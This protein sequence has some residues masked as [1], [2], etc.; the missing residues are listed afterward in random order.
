[1]ARGLQGRAKD[2]TGK[3]LVSRGDVLEEPDGSIQVR[4]V[5]LD[6]AD[7]DGHVDSFG[8]GT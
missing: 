6:I 1:M 4:A 5:E 8:L 2:Q 7:G 3:I